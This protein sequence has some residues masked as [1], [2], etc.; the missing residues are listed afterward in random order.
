MG[1]LR[2]LL[3][4]SVLCAHLHGKAVLGFR[5]LNGDLAVQCFY[6][7]SG[8]YMALVLNQK[9]RP[10][11]YALFLSQRYL[12]LWP[13]YAL[14]ALLSL[15]G[16]FL[17]RQAGGNDPG[18]FQAWLDHGSILDLPSR[19]ALVATNFAIV[20]QDWIVFHAINP[21]SGA[22][23]WTNYWNREPIPALSFLAIGQ[24]WS[25]GVEISFYLIAPWLVRQRYRLQAGLLLL[26]LAARCGGYAL[27][28]QG[29]PWNDRFFP[30]EL[31]F[32][33]AGSLAYQHYV[34]FPEW[35]ARLAPA[36]RNYGRWIFYALI[37][38][39]SR[40]PGHSEQRY[41]FMVP[42]LFALLPVLFYTTRDTAWDR[43]LGELSYP[44]Y[45][46]HTL[47]LLLLDPVLQARLPADTWGIIAVLATLGFSYLVF[48]YFELPIENWRHALL[49]K[50]SS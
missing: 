9:Y 33:L 22:L 16:E 24:A 40:L 50:Q 46:G 38:T 30:F 49:K 31:A 29:D 6:M 3:A 35:M 20:G 39:Y 21:H 27:G 5:F 45:L 19:L 15:I 41:Y 10:G 11:Q 34:R 25:L 42:L 23:Y 2:L 32:F 8:F 43:T 1:I 12:R 14:I 18:A 26:S 7:I 4:V 47:I 48:R 36:M 37:V 28:L 17:V 13:T 44:F